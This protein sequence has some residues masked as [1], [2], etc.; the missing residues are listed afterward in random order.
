MVNTETRNYRVIACCRTV[1]L[2]AQRTSGKTF[3]W[4][5]GAFAMSL[6][7]SRKIFKAKLN[8]N[9]KK[10]P[11]P[12][13]N[14]VSDKM[15]QRLSR[16]RGHGRGGTAGQDAAWVE[17]WTVGGSCAGVQGSRAGG[18]GRGAVPPPGQ[19]MLCVKRHLHQLPV[20]LQIR[21]LST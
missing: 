21:F 19:N 17:K 5:A 3:P 18:M 2:N 6:V 9:K 8:N 1:R 10:V 13:G 11:R 20:L 4:G 12:E 15:G 7:E 16:M 14:A